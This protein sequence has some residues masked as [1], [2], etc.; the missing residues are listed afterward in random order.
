MM[1]VA[2]LLCLA[3]TWTLQA[4]GEGDNGREVCQEDKYAGDDENQIQLHFELH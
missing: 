4:W 3:D 1:A 2:N